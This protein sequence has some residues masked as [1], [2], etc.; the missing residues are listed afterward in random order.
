[1]RQQI[2]QYDEPSCVYTQLP[3]QIVQHKNC[4]VCVPD[5]FEA[6]HARQPVNVCSRL[7]STAPG[8]SR[9]YTE[10]AAHSN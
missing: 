4:I 3:L 5:A 10:S 7:T 2:G 8:L 6:K 9:Q 1:M